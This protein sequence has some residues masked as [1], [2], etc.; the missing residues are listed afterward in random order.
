[1]IFAKIAY[2]R[3]V[4]N[5]HSITMVTCNIEDDEVELSIRAV[6]SSLDGQSQGSDHGGIHFARSD[7]DA[8][9]CIQE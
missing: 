7:M 3:Q 1:M 4:T 5:D 9:G 2:N 8:N 6:D